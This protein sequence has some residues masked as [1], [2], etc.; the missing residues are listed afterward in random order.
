MKIPDN[1]QIQ[2]FPATTP[3][4]TF[5]K[6][7]AD[8]GVAIITNGIP[9]DT[10]QRFHADIDNTGHATYLEDYKAFKDKEFPVQAKHASNLV[11]T[12]P[13]FRHEILNTPL[14]HEI[15][16][17]AFQHLGDYWLTSSI[18]RSTNPGNPAQDFH[19]DALFHPLLQYQSPSSPHLT[20]SLI[21]PTTPFTKANGA[22]RVILGSHKWDNMTPE[23]IGAVFKDDA[24]H[25]E[26]N[27]GDIMI[28]HQRTI[29]AGGEHL[30][31]AKD[32]RRLL[33]LLFTSCQLA[34]LESALAL[35]RPLVESLTPLA[36][37]MVG[38]RTVKPAG[39]NV[40]GLN[41]YHTG[42]LEDGLGLKSNQT[43]AG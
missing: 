37:K 17:A 36:Q 3:A 21:I 25:A 5:W 7:V 22:T 29:H 43:M 34:Q 1:P 6:A 31:E 40:V 14:I 18:F 4:P 39:V 28:L 23:K 12:S 30:S 35:P 16:S 33:L 8:D 42:T 2:R 9:I 10:I 13:V 15:C 26:L 38:W 32:T 19:R 24:V 20:V 11:R 27:A 41:T